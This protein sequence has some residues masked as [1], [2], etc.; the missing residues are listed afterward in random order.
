[1][2]EEAENANLTESGS[3]WPVKSRG[4]T[5]C[6]CVLVYI[7][8][9]VVFVAVTLAGLQD[10]NPTKLYAPRDYSGSYCGVDSNWQTGYDLNGFSS[11]GF[12]MNV[13]STTDMIVKELIC[14]NAARDALMGLLTTTEAQ[15]EYLCTCCLSACSRCTGAYKVQK[16]DS[17]NVQEIISG[18]MS[19]FQGS[20][21][22]LFNAKGM[23]GD[24]FTEIWSEA[25]KYFN[26]VCLPDCTV[27]YD[28]LN[29]TYRTWTYTM[30]ADDPFQPYWSLLNTSGPAV[31]KDTI[32]NSFTFKAFPTS[33]CPYAASKCVP[34][35]GVEFSEIMPGY[36]SLEV[37]E[38]VDGVMAEAL[39][40]MS[41]DAFQTE[42]EG[43]TSFGTLFGEALKTADTFA[44]VAV[45][46]VV[47]ALLYMVLLRF[48]VGTCVWLALFAVLVLFL[49]GGGL[50][51]ARSSQC[52]GAELFDTG[53]QMAV[54]TTTYL[55]S[56]ATNAVNQ[57]VD[58]NSYEV[59]SEEL[60]GD[61]GNGN[62]TGAQTRTVDGYSCIN[63]GTNGT[64]AEN[65]T[66][67]AYPNS[68]LTENYCRNPYLTGASADTKA[69]TIWCFTSDSE[70]TWQECQPIG[71]LR[72]A[73]RNGFAVPDETI[74]QILEYAAYTSWV[75]GAL[76]LFLI[77]CFCS[78]IREAIAINK[79][80]A[81]FVAGNPTL[82]LV[83]LIQAVLAVLWVGSWVFFASFLLS[84]VP[85]DY[86]PSGTFA[87]YA[88]AY[89]TATTPGQCTDKWP[90]GF[91][92]KDDDNCEIVNGTA[93]C[94]RCAQP[95]YAFDY[96]F[97]ASFFMLLWNN[98]FNIACGQFIVAGAAAAWFFT[99]NSEKG[100]RGSTRQAVWW[101]VR[102][103]LGSLA[104]GSFIIAV[105][106]FIRYCLPYLQKQAE[107]QKNR[108][109]VMILRITRCCLWCLE[110]FLKFINKNAYIQ[111]AINGH[112]FCTAAKKAFFLILNNALRF[113]AV[114]LLG[115][116]INFVG[117]VFIIAATVGLGYLYLLGMH[118][119][120]LPIFP[121]IS[122]VVCGY[123][124]SRLTLNV[125][126]L[127]VSTFQQCFL[128]C[129][130]EKDK[131]EGHH[132]FVPTQMLR[133][134]QLKPIE[135]QN[136]AD[137]DKE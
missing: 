103:H 79:V 58:P 19:E 101:A 54:A 10:G 62:Y 55:A 105:V 115:S 36:C 34:M 17:S 67:A 118:P 137:L 9:W 65:Y 109:M 3:P 81:I 122:Y 116:V 83:P 56:S 15:Q 45:T 113:G 29:T 38:L 98:A 57:A 104:F 108:V 8:G 82:L 133:I 97:A 31:I 32:T 89:G 92:Y 25:A 120:A 129:E 52:Q 94:W 128:L 13:T 30:A 130:E 95:R 68:N 77:L 59:L 135:N 117:Y 41:A 106:A 43:L 102:Y 1:M 63:W 75:I 74:R 126:G 76:Y 61:G 99:P 107:A 136:T 48:L 27:T 125:F 37:S 69:A 127:A 6:Y 46:C 78:R 16:L 119:E 64:D 53:F 110:N 124:V 86:T 33:I 80:A 23:N 5:D 7:F 14:S 4:C 131:I 50:L 114:A 40:S 39:E 49:F 66:Q 28:S 51:I 91:T 70:V 85:E 71:V 22:T 24:Y 132:D 73:C 26:M 123:V 112:N 20:A 72:P 60:L 44:C 12:T 134:L 121:I 87:T 88:E 2:A 96:R 93:Q 21:S 100:R 47:I 111:I 11:L 18:K 42:F 90:T 35:P 84:Q